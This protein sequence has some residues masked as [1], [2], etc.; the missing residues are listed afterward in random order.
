MKIASDYLNSNRS[1]FEPFKRV[2][3]TAIDVLPFLK[4]LPWNDFAL[5][6]VH[7]LRPSSIRII[8]DGRIK[9]DA[10]VWRVTV[11]LDENGLISSIY[12]EVE[13]GLPND[14]RNGFHMEGLLAEQ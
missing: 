1:V 12:Q 13:L 14:V 11:K 8:D 5:G 9:C 2:G 3:F 6:W 10:S 7:S 4:K